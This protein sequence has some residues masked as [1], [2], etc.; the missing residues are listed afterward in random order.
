MLCF[1]FTLYI[2]V[3]G[4]LVVKFGGSLRWENALKNIFAGKWVN[5]NN[6]KSL[7]PYSLNNKY[8][9]TSN[10]SATNAYPIIHC[11]YVVVYNIST[12][13]Y[14]LF[15]TYVSWSMNEFFWS[16]AILFPM[17]GML[18]PQVGSWNYWEKEP[19]AASIMVWDHFPPSDAEHS[20]YTVQANNKIWHVTA[21]CRCSEQHCMSSSTVFCHQQNPTFK[22]I[23]EQLEEITKECPILKVLDSNVNLFVPPMQFTSSFSSAGWFEK[24]PISAHFHGTSWGHVRLEKQHDDNSTWTFGRSTPWQGVLE[25]PVLNKK[26]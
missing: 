10:L 5:Q 4:E 12:Y 15:F 23:L 26:V 14:L 8:E 25:Q 18:G 17:Q 16:L 24:D 2:S 6:H 20:A 3:N 19:E 13:L 1:T 7:E 22:R 21:F 9:Y 11:I